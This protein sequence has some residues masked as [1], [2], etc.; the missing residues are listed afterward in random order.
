MKIRKTI[1][2]DLK[3]CERISQVSE[4][5]IDYYGN[6]PNAKYLREFLGPLFLLA[7]D[8]GKVVGYVCGEENKAKVVSLNILV[9][10]KNYR[11]LG[12]GKLLVNEF[13]KK[14]KRMK[15]KDVY[16]LSPKWNK[17][18]LNFYRKLG[19]FEMKNYAYFTKEIIK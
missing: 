6:K 7:E 13:I 19:F 10:D 4:L 17:K 8:S 9:V 16:L 14:A 12:I 5:D 3:E 11:G 18:T 15:Y 1:K 2:N